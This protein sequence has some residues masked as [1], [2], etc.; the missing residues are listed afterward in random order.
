MEVERI[1]GDT[2]DLYADF[3]KVVFAEAVVAGHRDGY[4]PAQLFDASGRADDPYQNLITV[5]EQLRESDEGM[6]RFEELASS[7]DD[8]V[9]SAVLIAMLTNE[10]LKQFDLQTM[11]SHKRLHR[12]VVE[13]VAGLHWD[14]VDLDANEFAI[15]EDLAVRLEAER[16]RMWGPQG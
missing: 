9:S 14:D 15:P 3:V 8:D 2:S 4:D 12:E 13:F 1:A 5:L 6:E 11:P 7:P 16:D 10:V